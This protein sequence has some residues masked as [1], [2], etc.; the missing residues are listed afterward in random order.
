ML[1]QQFASRKI[2]KTYIALVHGIPNTLDQNAVK[3]NGHFGDQVVW[4]DFIRKVHQQARAERCQETDP[5]AKYA[6]TLVTDCQYDER[7]D[8]SRIQLV[9]TTG[10]M[11]QLRLQAALRG[12][13]IVGDALYGS[14][15]QIFERKADDEVQSDCKSGLD[16]RILLHAARLQFFDPSDGRRIDVDS[17]CPF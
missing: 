10:R 9:P 7:P 3:S 1:S 4:R 13:P 16:T 8:A 12:S 15:S 6:E 5:G 14:K 11:H 17:Q 2:R